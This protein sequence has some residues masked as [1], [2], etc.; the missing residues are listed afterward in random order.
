MTEEDNSGYIVHIRVEP[1]DGTMAKSIIPFKCES[2]LE[3]LFEDAAALEAL[4]NYRDPS[5]S[6]RWLK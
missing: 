3:T 5:C 4:L 2:P 1:A 6:Y